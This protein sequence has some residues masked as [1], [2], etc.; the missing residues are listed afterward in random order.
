MVKILFWEKHCLAI[1]IPSN[2][3]HTLIHEYVNAMHC[4]V[5][6]NNHSN[7]N[8]SK[9]NLHFHVTTHVAQQQHQCQGQNTASDGGYV[10]GIRAN[11]LQ[12][13]AVAEMLLV[14]QHFSG[15]ACKLGRVLVALVADAVV[16]AAL[17]CQTCAA[18]KLWSQIFP[19]RNENN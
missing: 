18:V 2:R 11:L 6:N 7:R 12:L 3:N 14:W 10:C 8:Q 16:D 13:T 9:T 17:V 19:S 4:H 15:F 1:P 5:D